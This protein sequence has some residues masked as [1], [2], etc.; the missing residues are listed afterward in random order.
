MVAGYTHEELLLWAGI[1]CYAAATVT[2]WSGAL[3]GRDNPRSVLLWLSI[4]VVVF[5]LAIA[6]RW[7]RLDY[8][9]FLT[10]YEI[11]LSNLFSLGLIYTLLY[12]TVPAVR[13]GALVA[14]PLLLFIGVWITT[15]S[16]APSQLPATYDNPWL[17]VHVSIGKL[18]LGA[19]L[20]AVGVAALL[21]LRSVPVFFR[22]IT[23]SGEETLDQSVWRLMA[24]AFVFHSLMLIAGAV[25]AQD[26]W[27]RFWSWDP[28]ETW[29]F[30]TW[31]VLGITLH[32]RVTYKLPNWI[33]WSMVSVVF[34]LAFLTFFGVPFVSHA[35]HKGI[36]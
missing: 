10:L 33:G 8:G 20:A 21:L 12:R 5:A 24:A 30:I 27:G 35:P 17:W 22:A 3:A 32:A 19:A 16:P 28:L 1:A 31:L 29:A 13:P 25:W 9:P 4:G 6:E 18:F 2:Q 36:L 14:L 11:L 15:V 23:R 34:V 7:L 26:A